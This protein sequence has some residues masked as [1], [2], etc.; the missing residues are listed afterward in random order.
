MNDGIRAGQHLR[1]L[2]EVRD[3]RAQSVPDEIDAEDVVAVLDEVVDHEP[4]GLPARPCDHDA[5]AATL[6]VV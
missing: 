4:A 3:V 6:R 5:H 2:T 1:G